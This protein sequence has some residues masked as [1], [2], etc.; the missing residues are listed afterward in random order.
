MIKLGDYIRQERE[1]RNFTQTE[2]AK[3]VGITGQFLSN[4]ERDVCGVPP[5]VLA[6]MIAVL[7][8]DRQEIVDLMVEKFRFS[9]E[10][11]LLKGR[12]KKR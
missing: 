9:I 8:I 7:K 10:E 2:V 1:K 3:K 4:M 11:Q 12:R 6:K 5:K